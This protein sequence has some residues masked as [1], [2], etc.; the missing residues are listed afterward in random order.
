MVLHDIKGA[1]HIH[2]TMN[3]GIRNTFFKFLYILRTLLTYILKYVIFESSVVLVFK[4]YNCWVYTNIA[5]LQRIPFSSVDAPYFLTL[6][7]SIFPHLNF[8]NAVLQ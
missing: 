4:F 3:N 2:N 5:E 8:T 7:N 6:C 1:N